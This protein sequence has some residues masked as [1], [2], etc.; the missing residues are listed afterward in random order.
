M[1]SSPFPPC[2]PCTVAAHLIWN[3]ALYWQKIS[4]EVCLN[5]CSMHS[6]L[7]LLHVLSV[8]LFSWI[9][10]WRGWYCRSSQSAQMIEIGLVAAITQ[11]VCVWRLPIQIKFVSNWECWWNTC[12]LMQSTKK[13]LPVIEIFQHQHNWN[14]V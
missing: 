7:P 5:P 3:F 14:K 1:C 8:W 11:S 13:V 10:G 9:W 6:L 4:H 2:N 12:T